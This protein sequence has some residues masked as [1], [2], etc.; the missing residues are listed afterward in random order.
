MQLLLLQL[1]QYPLYSD[2]IEKLEVA[3]PGFVNIFIK[4]SFIQVDDL[5]LFV[6][7][8]ARVGK[9]PFFFF[10]IPTQRVFLGFIGFFWEFFLI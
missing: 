6:I 4:K 10:L 7:L 3:G 9:N 8:L 2:L 5:I 1:N